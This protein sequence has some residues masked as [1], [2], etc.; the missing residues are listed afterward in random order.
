[1]TSPPAV[2]HPVDLFKYQRA[3][4]DA[5]LKNDRLLLADDMG[6]GKTVQAVTA[7]RTLARE[8]LCRRALI[9]APAGLISQWRRELTRWAPDLSAIVVSGPQSDRGWQWRADPTVTIVGYETL[10][11]DADAGPQAPPL[12]HVWD[13]VILDEAQKIKNRDVKVSSLVKNLRRA[14]SWVL[15]GT[16]LENKLDELASLLE[17]LDGREDGSHPLYTPS[18]RLLERHAQVQLRRKK[19]DVLP[20]LPPK[21][22][23][24]LEIVLGRR[25]RRA[26]DRAEREGILELRERG[27]ELR[28]QHVLEL[29]LRLKQLCNFEPISGKSAKLDDIRERLITLTAQGHRALLFSQYIDRTYGVQALARSLSEFSPLTFTGDLDSGA[30]DDVLNRFKSNP[31]HKILLLSLRAGGAGLNLQEASYVFHMDRWWNPAVEHQ[32]EDRSHRLGQMFPVTV[33]TYTCQGTIE[34]RI[35][36]ILQSKQALFETFV[37]DVSLDVASTLR[38]EELF[39]LFGLR[40]PLIPPQGLPVSR[41]NPAAPPDRAH[42]SS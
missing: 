35:Q 29:I 4:V 9:V 3:G 24:N 32:A 19:A 34:E 6:L 1:M 7:L 11:S 18:P 12:R 40:P 21:L 39:G 13:L 16:P 2:S 42:K 28:I 26:Y 38:S 23:T 30:R 8:G 33:F 17:F 37:D 25:Q 31:S 10:R 14:R 20:D 41:R 22:V 15:T 27:E 36:E 5:L